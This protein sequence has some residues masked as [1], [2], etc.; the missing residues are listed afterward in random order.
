LIL[1]SSWLSPSSQPGRC[2]IGFDNYQAIE[3]KALRLEE[4]EERCLLA[5][6]P[7]GK[8]T[9]VGVMSL[10]GDHGVPAA[11]CFNKTHT[12]DPRQS[13]EVKYLERQDGPMVRP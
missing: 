5:S 7:R 9:F 10:W 12:L 2:N 11:I 13:L 8:D 4:T 3:D 1:L 6:F